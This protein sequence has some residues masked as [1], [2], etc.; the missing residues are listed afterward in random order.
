[1]VVAELALNYRTAAERRGAAACSNKLR[2]LDSNRR[3]HSSGLTYISI[4]FLHNLIYAAGNVEVSHNMLLGRET[5]AHVRLQPPTELRG[6]FEPRAIRTLATKCWHNG[7]SLS[8]EQ[9][10]ACDGGRAE[11]EDCNWSENRE[12][13]VGRT[14]RNK[15][16]TRIY[17]ELHVPARH[18]LGFV[19][20]W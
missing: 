14:R 15:S 7:C 20:L 19:V 18:S 2:W 3:W 16:I 1:M 11:P 10:A 4:G 13:D 6:T 12:S 17:N 5:W 8:G 9:S